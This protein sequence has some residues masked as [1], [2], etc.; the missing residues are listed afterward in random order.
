[1]KTPAVERV[2]LGE[3]TLQASLLSAWIRGEDGWPNTPVSL[4]EPFLQKAYGKRVRL[5][6]EVIDRPGV[7][8][9]K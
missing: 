6:L 5:V 2:V 7:K 8:H 9:G 4:P 1:M 3:G